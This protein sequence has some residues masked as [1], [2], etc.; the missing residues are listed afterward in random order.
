MSAPEGPTIHGNSAPMVRAGAPDLAAA[1]DAQ[2]TRIG[3]T[4]HRVY[5]FTLVPR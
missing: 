3:A 2:A 4:A 1:F 5:P